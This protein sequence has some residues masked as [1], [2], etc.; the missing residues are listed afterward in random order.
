MKHFA[1]PDFWHHYQE[2]PEEIRKLADKNF[3][4]LK[5]HPEN[6]NLR[7][8]KVGIFYSVRVGAHYRAVAKT[9]K[10]GMVWIWIGHHTEY[11]QMLK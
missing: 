10:E 8:K 4:I 5:T 6:P 7:F 9:R 3:T 1:S 2:L 11:D